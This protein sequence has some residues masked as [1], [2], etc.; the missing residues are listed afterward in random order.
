VF[1]DQGGV[2]TRAQALAGGATAEAI[3]AHLRAGQWRRLF[4]STYA[5]FSG[6]VPRESVLWSAVLCGGAGAALSHRSAGEL[7]G[8]VDEPCA[9]IHL[10]VPSRRRVSPM[11]G[12]VVHRSVRAESARHPSRTPPRTTIE[13]TVIDLADTAP[14]LEQAM[15]WITRACARRLTRP[16]RIVAALAARTRVRWRDD[17]VAALADVAAGAHSSLELRYL[18]DVE[19]AHRL[20]VGLRQHAVARPGGRYYDDVR[21]QEYG[22]TVE[23]DG[24]SAHPDD[25]RW[26]DM[27][28]D[29]ASVLAGRRVLRFGWADVAGGPCAVAAQVAVVLRIAGWRGVPR[30]CRPECDIRS[31]DRGELVGS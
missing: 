7:W 11:P 31:D 6:P 9:P 14:G 18:R 19:R 16:D 20:P 17:L 28:R 8:L 2:V 25:A 22:V 5:T 4:R 27:R 10:V 15:G 21:Y 13:E 23:L 29:N 24:R 30:P 1:E 26:R 3:R 12:V